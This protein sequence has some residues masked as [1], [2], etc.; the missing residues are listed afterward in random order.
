MRIERNFILKIMTTIWNLMIINVHCGG[1]LLCGFLKYWE[2]LQFL[3][4]T[5]NTI[6]KYPLVHTLWKRFLWLHIHASSP[7][8]QNPT[9][10][11]Q[12]LN[13]PETDRTPNRSEDLRNKFLQVLWRY[14]AEESWET[15][16]IVFLLFRQVSTRWE[17]DAS[18]RLRRG[19]HGRKWG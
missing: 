11:L 16:T 17:E 15:E 5:E 8:I 4:H 2:Q 14:L 1:G 3:K 7:S 10:S 13:L 19:A 18:V 12:S 6:L 9:N